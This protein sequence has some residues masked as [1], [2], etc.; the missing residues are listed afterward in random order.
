MR[1]LARWGAYA[2]LAAL[3]TTYLLAKRDYFVRYNE[4]SISSYLAGHWGYWIVMLA[5]AGLAGILFWFG[6]RIEVPKSG[7]SE[8][9]RL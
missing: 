3:G 5:F 9:E 8:V 1:H 6:D 4:V 2:S 7:S